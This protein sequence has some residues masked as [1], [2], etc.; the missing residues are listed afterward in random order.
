MGAAVFKTSRAQLHSKQLQ[1]HGTDTERALT[2]MIER[3]F[4]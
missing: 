1:L 2:Q 4:F 3:L